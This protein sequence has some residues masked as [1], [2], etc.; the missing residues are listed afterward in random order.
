MSFKDVRL[1]FSLLFLPCLLLAQVGNDAGELHGNFQIDAQYYNKD[2]AIGAP[3]VPEKLRMNAFGNLIYTR[4]KL[5]AGMRYE[6]Y[7]NTLLGFDPRYDGQGIPFRFVSYD[8]ADLQIT[9]GNF[10]EQFGSGVI[11]RAYEERGL[12][13]DNVFDG[14]RVK[15][16]LLKGIRLTG[17]VGRQ[18]I[19]F[20]KSPG[21]VR[22]F[23]ADFSFNELF[24]VMA[25]N[26]TKIFLGATFVS[27][28]QEDQDPVFELPEN[29]GCYG[30]RLKIV[31]EKI[32][33][34]GEYA[35]KINDPSLVNQINGVAN[36]N[37]GQAAI[38]SAAYSQK[39]FGFSAGAKYI[40][41]MNFRSDRDASGNNLLI[42]FMPALTRQ[43][44]YNLAATIYPY[45]TQPNGELALQAELVY[46]FK[47]E[48]LLGGK[49]GTEILINYSS[50]NG[51]D[52]AVRAGAYY[53]DV[54]F[55]KAGAAYFKD[56]NIEIHKRFSKTFEATLFYANFLYNKD[57]VQGLSGFGIINADIAVIEA[58]WRL[59]K[60]HAL[61][62]E[63][64][65]LQTDQ[66]MGD[67]LAGLV[68]YTISPNWFFA[69]VT[70]YNIGNPDPAARLVYPTF[71]MGYI[72]NAARITVGYGRQRAGIFCVGG[73]CRNVPASNGL[74]I[75]ISSS[76]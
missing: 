21:I 25:D 11:L 35:Y 16:T 41:N 26:K 18:R 34:F 27:K 56:L 3:V 58:T 20:E 9:L 47:K 36:Y 40:D 46:K 71:T 7:Q 65:A 74:T 14:A 75:S 33:V 62:I 13:Y 45:A 57:V 28:F 59:K 55:S 24:P 44:T 2:S 49:Y 64:E 61:R 12:G 38:I 67:W 43:H 68:E 15:Y 39:G 72:K 69:T 60:S 54:N 73:I 63:L 52:T 5:S 22:G 4:G 66:D 10:Y 1:F 6:A 31:R 48:S 51:L 70:Q 19:F 32:N 30:G 29:V 53:Y 76:F 37:P 17:L 42:N 8:D 23:D 50:A